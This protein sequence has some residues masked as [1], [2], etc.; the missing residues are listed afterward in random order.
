MS[1]PRSR[2]ALLIGMTVLT[3]GLAVWAAWPP[4][5]LAQC[6]GG[7]QPPESS[8][9]AC[10]AIAHPVLG[11]GEWHEIHARKDCCWNCHGGNDQ[12]QDKD[13]AH[14][15]L[16]SHPLEDPYTNCHACH[17]DDYQQRAERFAV[18][19]GVTPVSS[20][21]LTPTLVALVPSGGQT[22]T[23]SPL[24]PASPQ[25]TTALVLLALLA[26]FFVSVTVAARRR[27]HP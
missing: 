5:A 18:A 23:P 13:L 24:T 26:V 1:G 2:M 20:K 27:A 11:Q 19:L 4:L 22:F 3:L 8:C 21:P 6:G 10:H 17:P 12:A 16:V 7:D 9:C 14:I 25:W 15:G